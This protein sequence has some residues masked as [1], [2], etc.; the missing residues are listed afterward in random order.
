MVLA[1]VNTSLYFVN[2][3]ELLYVHVKELLC[4]D[5]FTYMESKH[6]F[7][8]PNHADVYHYSKIKLATV[9]FLF[10]IC[11]CHRICIKLDSI[12]VAHSTSDMNTVDQSVR[13]KAA[14]RCVHRKMIEHSS[15]PTSNS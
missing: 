7:A 15:S 5:A 8:W 9:H 12:L 2:V 14:T 10:L 11:L 4:N 1:A 6:Y 3:K 13:A